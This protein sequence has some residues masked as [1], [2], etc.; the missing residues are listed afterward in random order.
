MS[1]LGESIFLIATSAS[2]I[3]LLIFSRTVRLLVWHCLRHP[4]R[5]ADIVKYPGKPAYI[6]YPDESKPEQ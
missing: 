5:T 6:E 3:L 4:L 2:F 1:K